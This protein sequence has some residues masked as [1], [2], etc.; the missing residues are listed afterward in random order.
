MV[1]I[2]ALASLEDVKPVD[3]PSVL[4]DPLYDFIDPEALDVLVTD[5]GAISISFTIADYDIQIDGDELRI[6]YK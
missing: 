4:D 3:L 6:H 1:I 2:D 5:K